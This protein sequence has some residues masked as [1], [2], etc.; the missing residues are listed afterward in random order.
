MTF[1]RSQ[2]RVQHHSTIVRLRLARRARVAYVLRTVPSPLVVHRAR[3]LLLVVVIV[4]G[5]GL[6][7]PT[8]AHGTPIDDKRAEAA[9]LTQQINANGDRISALGEQFN[10]AQI[11][12]DAAKA[13][14]AEAEARL[15]DAQAN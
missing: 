13:S 14:I 7:S 12:V 1:R 2:R 4:V 15:N 11:K 5:A 6:L 3:A 10:E 8:R 9:R